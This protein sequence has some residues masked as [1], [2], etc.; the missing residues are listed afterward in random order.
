[1]A[2]CSDVSDLQKLLLDKDK[3]ELTFL[4]LGN[5]G[6]GKT[7]FINTFVNVFCYNDLESA[8]QHN[9]LYYLIPTS[10]NHENPEPTRTSAERR[11]RVKDTEENNIKLPPVK[12]SIGEHTP[13]ENEKSMQSCTQQPYS[14]R[15][16]CREGTVVNI[17]DTPGVWRYTWR[18]QG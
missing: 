7:I 4:L 9:K 12:I 11:R 1:M 6:V 16:R 10:F 8:L 5:S 14:Y 17:I 3:K 18:Q 15:I 13:N 2:A